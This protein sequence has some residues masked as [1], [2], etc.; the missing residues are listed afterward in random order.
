MGGTA[1]QR[2][3]ADITRRKAKQKRMSTLKKRGLIAG[4]VVMVAYS[5]FGVWWLAA[6]DSIAKAEKMTQEYLWGMTARAGFEVRQVYLEGRSHLP[7]GELKQALGIAQGD[8]IL[9]VSLGDMRARLKALPEVRDARIERRLPDTM[10]VVIEERMPIALWQREGAYAVI[11]RDGVVLNRAVKEMP[12]GTL[13][14]VGDDAPK[15]MQELM[16]L[17]AAS[18]ALAP[19]V[20]AAVRV[21]ERRWNM[22]LKQG[23]TVMLPEGDA[24]Q[25]WMKFAGLVEKERLLTKAVR[26]VDMRLE[27]RVFVTPTVGPESPKV[28]TSARDT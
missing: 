8:P 13:L 22:R 17:M 26:T 9:A 28:L 14:V 12:E 27:D 15:H 20:E 6:H 1:R 10:H 5:A 11:D 19:D 4:G 18:P 23:I 7:Q 2:A 21:G 16:A 25:A 24:K 3:S